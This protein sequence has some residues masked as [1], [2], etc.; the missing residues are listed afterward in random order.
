MQGA[1][2]YVLP[3]DAFSWA[4]A[5]DQRLAQACEAV[6]NGTAVVH[7]A[8]L[9]HAGYQKD[10]LTFPAKAV[11]QNA[12]PVS[13]TVWSGTYNG[14]RGTFPA[15]CVAKQ[16]IPVNYQHLSG[17]FKMRN[18][19]VLASF[20][21]DQLVADA[22]VDKSNP[23]QVQYL[24]LLSHKNDKETLEL[25]FTSI[26]ELKRTRAA[27]LEASRNYEARVFRWI[28]YESQLLG[29][30]ARIAWKVETVPFVSMKHT[31]SDPKLIASVDERQAIDLI[32][33]HNVK[34]QQWR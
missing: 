26:T 25:R 12:K 34:V 5:P 17:S 31:L 8:K 21:L 15:E 22:I 11:I 14:L 20:S 28:F 9:H 13:D 4:A 23:F 1:V 32:S 29:S 30:L 7:C 24:L 18:N 27:L 10:E 16:A 19:G 2:E 3:G 33:A 6:R